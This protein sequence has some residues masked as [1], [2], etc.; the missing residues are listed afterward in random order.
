MFE[1]L[2]AR[3]AGRQVG[4]D[5]FGNAYWES[6]KDYSGYGRKRRWVLYAGAAEASKVP[7]EWH[8]WLHH[9]AEAHLN[10]EKRHG[11]MVDHR[12]NATGTAQAYRPDGHDYQ[13]GSRRLTAG[14]YEAWTP[15]S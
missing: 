11:W 9:T 15:G 5:R 2:L 13:G 4:T 14:D 6:R 3:L 10:D 12:P 1:R 7:P 8:G